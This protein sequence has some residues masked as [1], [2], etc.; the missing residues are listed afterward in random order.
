MENKLVYIHDITGA[1]VGT[2]IEQESGSLDHLKLACRVCSKLVDEIGL[3][4]HLDCADH[5]LVKILKNNLQ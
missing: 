3:D 4:A 2:A 5:E 1:I